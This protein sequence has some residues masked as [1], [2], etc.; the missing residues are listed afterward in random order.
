MTDLEKDK[1]LAQDILA[2][3]G[4]KDNVV[5]LIHCITRLRF[6]LKD[7]S[8]ADDDAIGKLKGVISVVHS[9]GQYQVVIGNKVTD[10]YDQIMPM[11]GMTN[12]ESSSEV[13]EGNLGSRFVSTISSLFFPM[14]G[15]MTGAGLLKGILVLLS[16]TNI[17]KENTGTYMIL[18]AAG[19][20]LFYFLPIILG[21]S[22]A[23][24]FKVNQYLGA[25]VGAALV[26]PTMTAAYTAGKAITFLGIPVTLMNYSQTMLPVVFAVWGMSYLEKGLNKVIPKV[27]RNIFVPFLDLIITIPLAYL[28]VGPVMQTISQLLADGS[29]W[30]YGIAP[31]IA[32][33]I[34]GGI[35]QGAVIFGLHYAFIP[36]LINNL[37][38]NG[39]DP[40]NG[41]FYCTLFG[42][43]GAALGMALKAK[44]NDFK[45]IAIP[46]AVSGFFGITEPIIYGVTLPHKKAFGMAS[47][48]SA[49]GGA[50]AAFFHAGMYTM[51]GGGIFGIPAFLNP[52]E[53]DNSFYG[54]IASL[55]IAFGVALVLTL[56]FGDVVVSDD[57][58]VDDIK[59]IQYKDEEIF[60]PVSGKII[61]LK[62][63][64]DTVF[65]SEA[66]GK[67]VAI[68]PTDGEIFAPFDGKVS[69][70]FPT[71]H[72]IGLKSDNG[73][74]LL[75]HIGLDT[76]ELQGENFETFV[77][78]GMKVKKGDLLEKF[79]ISKI[80]EAGYDTVIPVVV[81]NSTN[82]DDIVTTKT[83]SEVKH[84]E[85]LLLAM[86]DQETVD[87]DNLSQA[88]LN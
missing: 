81:T 48:G 33:F 64:N 70:I 32:G 80:K 50:V 79:D 56:I 71:K 22:S 75:I 14:L 4:G 36:I 85:N 49:F 10:I 38:T 21:F 66:V 2:L 44:D 47:I 55:I 76:V 78:E 86:I 26:Y 73:V 82:F 58:N 59:N 11:L 52:K 6:T 77:E 88:V 45:E 17:V 68:L 31:V 57:E 43:V 65:S 25:L 34:L 12:Q 41:I 27:V 18:N 24:T 28:I 84:G 19:D 69:T 13:K 83:S 5:K 54:F 42:Q 51:P 74:E 15:V 20:S 40:I 7:E 9:G 87:K 8:I 61:A 72:A 39:F 67:G 53:I 3:V 35:W 1:A 30:I 62:D 23:K 16:V 29:I 37:T 46:A 60:A 63:V